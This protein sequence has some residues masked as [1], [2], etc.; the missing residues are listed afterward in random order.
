MAQQKSFAT[1]AAM[2]SIFSYERIMPSPPRTICYPRRTGISPARLSARC[3]VSR[4]LRP[5]SRRRG[6]CRAR[7]LCGTSV[8]FSSVSH[9]ATQHPPRLCPRSQKHT[10]CGTEHPRQYLLILLTLAV[11]CG[12][13]CSRTQFRH[14]KTQYS[15]NLVAC[16]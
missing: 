11:T 16:Q 5:C 8:R 7:A 1:P 9:G 4:R 15:T 2:C 12:K 13:M 6:T 14:C 10:P 3:S